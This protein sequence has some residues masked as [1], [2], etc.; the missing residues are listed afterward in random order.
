M[1]YEGIGDYSLKVQM[2]EYAIVKSTGR[3][4]NPLHSEA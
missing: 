4:F 1:M 2:V 3:D